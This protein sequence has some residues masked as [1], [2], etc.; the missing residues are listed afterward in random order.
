MGKGQRDCTATV[1]HNAMNRKKRCL[2]DKWVFFI[3][4][5][6][7]FFRYRSHKLLVCFCL[8]QCVDNVQYPN[9]HND[10]ASK[11]TQLLVA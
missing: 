10:I 5:L 2:L 7:R 11:K 8:P 3:Q 1:F 6:P 4:E 9:T